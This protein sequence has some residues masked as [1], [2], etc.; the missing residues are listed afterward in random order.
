MPR[1]LIL[2]VPASA[3]ARVA[4]LRDGGTEL[5]VMDGKPADGV[6]TIGEV[7]RA[8]LSDPADCLLTAMRLHERVPL[9]G[10]MT[11]TEWAVPS[12]AAIAQGLR[13]R[14][15]TYDTGI[16]LRRK[17]EMRR[18]WAAAG[19]PQPES[20]AAASCDEAAEAAGRLGFPCVVKPA[21]ASASEGVS[22]VEE[23]AGVPAAYEAAARAA[24]PGR[25]VLVEEF[26]RGAEVSVETV[27]CDAR[28]HV[29]AVTAKSLGPLPRFVEIGH[30]VPAPFDSTERDDVVR[31]TAAAHAALGCRYGVTHTEFKLT[32]RGPR[33]IEM[34]GRPA[35]DKIT[36]LVRLVYGVELIAAAAAAA[37]GLFTPP[38]DHA[39]SGAA[40]I[41][42]VCAAPGRVS[43]VTGLEEARRLVGV[44]AVEVSARPGDMVPPLHRSQD[45]QGYVIATGVTGAQAQARAAAACRLLRIETAAADAWGSET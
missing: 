8:D 5:V 37:I 13:L 39:A 23:L 28:P 12:C 43:R 2:G 27:V 26:V 7:V 14:G 33:L 35:G 24:R 41:R 17:D 3:V 20:I 29:V 22:L 30:L 21:D 42:F 40:A 38:A 36:T 34:A 18:R 15:N 45:R 11:L 16:S 9:D 4:A 25:H 32:D 44:E 19:L 31:L 10:V 6:E 1:L